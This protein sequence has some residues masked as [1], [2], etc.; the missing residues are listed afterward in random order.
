MLS[1]KNLKLKKP[2][3]KLTLKFIR[4]FQIKNI[5][6]KQ[7]YKLFLLNIYLKLHLIFPII[8]L[9]PYKKYPNNFL[10]SDL[11]MLN[12]TNE[13]TEYKIKKIIN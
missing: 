10:K 4:L 8:Y 5:I 9:K 13:N 2:N 6:G 11:S 12:F 7:A 1:T 3:K